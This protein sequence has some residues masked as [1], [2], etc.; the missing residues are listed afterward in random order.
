MKPTTLRYLVSPS[1]KKTTTLSHLTWSRHSHAVYYPR[2]P[3]PAICHEAHYPRAPTSSVA[4][5]TTLG[6]LV[7]PSVMRPTTLGRLL[8]PSV[9]RP[10]TLGHLVLVLGTLHLLVY[11]NDMPSCIQSLADLFPDDC[12]VFIKIRSTADCVKL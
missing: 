9:M 12:L 8:S 11:I 7:S 1:F 6:H 10:T 3:G 2:T 5:P 4:K